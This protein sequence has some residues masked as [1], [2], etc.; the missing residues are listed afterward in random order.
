MDGCIAEN[1]CGL[2]IE[3]LA[4]AI[5]LVADMNGTEPADSDHMRAV[6]GSASLPDYRRYGE[7]ARRAARAAIKFLA[8]I[9]RLSLPTGMVG[10]DHG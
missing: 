8:E 3:D 5:Y 2:I 10:G 4:R 6:F 9:D 7:R 1:A